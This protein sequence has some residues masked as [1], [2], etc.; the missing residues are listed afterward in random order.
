MKIIDTSLDSA[1]P[2]QPTPVQFATAI[3]EARGS[4]DSSLGSVMEGLIHIRTKQDA[5]WGEQNHPDFFPIHDLQ[6]GAFLREMSVEQRQT[7]YQMPSSDDAKKDC[8]NDAKR[9]KLSW[10]AILKEEVCEAFDSLTEEELEAELYDVLGV[11][12]AWIQAI[13]RRR[14]KRGGK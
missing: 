11:T 13:R 9:G 3:I 2:P 12:A 14:E 10:G 7:Y 4:G 8:D 5:K 6:T 1:A